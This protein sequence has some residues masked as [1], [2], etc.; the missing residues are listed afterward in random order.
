MP[1]SGLGQIG[2]PTAVCVVREFRW[3]CCMGPGARNLE[4]QA[5]GR[6]IGRIAGER[7]RSR[8]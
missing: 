5:G 4:F 8:G 7:T 1:S 6:A 2:V 3:G